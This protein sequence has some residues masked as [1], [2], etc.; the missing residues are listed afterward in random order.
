M[1]WN[2]QPSGVRAFSRTLR[3]ILG[4]SWALLGLSWDPLGA[5]LGPLVDILGSLGA[6]WGYH[7]AIL[8]HPM[9]FQ[10]HLGALV[11]LTGALPGAPW[12]PHRVRGRPSRGAVGPRRVHWAIEGPSER[13]REPHPTTWRPS[14]PPPLFPPLSLM[15]YLR[16]EIDPIVKYTQLDLA[17]TRGFPSGA[18]FR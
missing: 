4:S 14:A 1:Q 5:I 17:S 7:E 6:P 16:Q 9:T 13:G 11:G 15:S 8:A 10:G 18:T 2:I 12:S 3:A